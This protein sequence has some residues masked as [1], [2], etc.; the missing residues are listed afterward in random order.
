MASY[1]PQASTAPAKEDLAHCRKWK[2]ELA[3]A[4]RREKDWVSC[5]QKI[6]KRYR[7]EEARRN[8]YNILWANTETLGPAI[9]NS[10][11][12]PDVRRR[13][14][15]ADPVGKAVSEILDR[16]LIFTMDGDLADESLQNDV[17]DALLPGRGVSRVLYVPKI[18]SAGAPKPKAANPS[19]KAVKSAETDDDG[20]AGGSGDGS[21]PGE[22]VEQDLQELEFEQAVIEHVDWEDFRHGYGR[23]WPEVEWVGFRHKMIRGDATEKFGRKQLAGIDFAVDKAEDGS[24]YHEQTGSSAK[25]AEFWEIWSKTEGKVF[26]LNSACD[27]CLYPLD[28]P[29]GEPPIDFPD[30][31]PC[32]KPLMLVANTSSLL[33]TAPFTLY[34]D[35][36]NQ[37]D[38][39]TARIDK[40]VKALRLRGVYDA[41]LAEIPDLLS[42]DDNQLTPVKNAAIWADSGGLEKAI[43]WMPIEQAAA[44]LQH[45]Y[46]ARDRQKAIIDELTGISDIVRGTTDPDET[47]GAQELKSGYHSVRL[48]KMQAEV[49]RYARDLLRLVA[50]VMCQKFGVDTFQAMTDLK[51]PTAE[52]KQLL[53]QMAQMQAQQPPIQPPPPQ[54]PSGPPGVPSGDP[55]QGVPAAPAGSPPVGAGQG[56]ADAPPDL[57]DLLKVPTWEDCM[58]LMHSPS[59]RQFRIDVETDSTIS[60]TIDSDMAGLS[61]VLNA[62]ATA[63]KELGPLVTT[64]V[65]PAEA[66]KQ[67][68]MTII[69]R[70]RMGSAV[71]DAFDKMTKPPPQPDPKA[72]EA[73]AKAAADVQSAQAKAAA[74]VQKTQAQETTKQHTI[75]VQAAHDDAQQQRQIEADKVAGQAKL[76][77]EQQ[78][79]TMRQEGQRQREQF[80]ESAKTER[81]HTQALFD[82]FIKIITAT[83][84]ATK[85]PDEKVQGRADAEVSSA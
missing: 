10:K 48:W 7:G 60:G 81:E 51:L 33:P 26:F 34:E 43:A 66:A 83:I 18:T 35:Q 8:K 53:Q 21:Q 38:T 42:G 14:S 41:K 30:F 5:G 85:Q 67:L 16:S 1:K 62:I 17:L 2:K 23:S 76:A 78:L 40:I 28:N 9:Y 79:E 72:A 49:K 37:L 3:L 56:G 68:I 64:G 19:G 54:G 44:V 11:P 39:L 74:D 61:E 4:E 45:L 13:F 12:A 69:R 31:F 80:A 73:Q 58:A 55:Q 52:Q 59:M 36:A 27:T 82:G 25:V 22:G 57:A 84:A 15:D 6:I 77:A 47:L 46:E 32:P 29:D 63:L 75:D 50:A 70:S 65:L 71:E 20:D 24:K